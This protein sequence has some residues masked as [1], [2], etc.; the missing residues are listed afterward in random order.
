[1]ESWSLSLQ[2]PAE[3]LARQSRSF[4]TQSLR[5]TIRRWKL[6]LTCGLR[7]LGKPK[8]SRLGRRDKTYSLLLIASALNWLVCCL[9]MIIIC[10]KIHCRRGMDYRMNWSSLIFG[11][12]ILIFYQRCR[13]AKNGT[14]NGAYSAS[15]GTDGEWHRTSE[16]GEG[17]A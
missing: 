11:R 15:K 6:L 10:I 16:A 2:V 14:G 13:E 7:R 8:K 12:K 3:R 4:F 9:I 5:E 17:G 1:M